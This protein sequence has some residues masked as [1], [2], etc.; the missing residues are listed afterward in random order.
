MARPPALLRFR[1]FAYQ[2][3]RGLADPG[4]S[5]NIRDLYRMLSAAAIQDAAITSADALSF[6]FDINDSS[7]MIPSFGITPYIVP[8]GP[9]PPDLSYI[10][11]FNVVAP[12]SGSHSLQKGLAETD[13]VTQVPNVAA[14]S[15]GL[16]FGGSLTI[17]VLD[18]IGST[19]PWSVT[20]YN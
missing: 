2:H 6:G 18:S 1:E 9:T 20:S 12:V 3:A 15:P 17:L 8:L 5:A 16:Y 14:E 19:S 7:A 13:L 10:T 11:A 4:E